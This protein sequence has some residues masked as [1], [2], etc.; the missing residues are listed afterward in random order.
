VHRP[1]LATPACAALYCAM[2]AGAAL[3]VAV[4]LAFSS[5]LPAQTVR[6][7]WAGAVYGFGAP[8]SI[9]L[10]LDSSA[11]GWTGRL[12]APAFRRDSI[13]FDS[14]LVRGDSV[15]T[16]FTVDGHSVAFHTALGA[17]RERIDGQVIV[18]KSEIGAVRLGRAGS[19]LAGALQAEARALTSPATDPAAPPHADPDSARLV[20][21]DVA[22]FWN[23]VDHAKPDSLESALEHEYLDKASVGVH[24][25]IPGRILSAV[26]LAH[27]FRVSRDRYEASRASSSRVVEAT[28]AIRAAF[29]QLKALYPPAVFPDVYFVIG[30]FNS[31]GTSSSHG[32]LIGA[33]MYNDPSKLPGIVAHELIHFEQTPR[34]HATL[35][36]RSF[37]EGSADFVGEMISGGNINSDRFQ[38]GVA[39]EHEL[40]ADFS[41][42]MHGTDYTGWLYGK[43][44]GERPAD[45]GYFIGYRIASAYYAKASDKRQALAEIIRGADVD[46]LLAAS[47]YSP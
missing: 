16:A 11:S 2:R 31:G 8:Q 34:A 17:G 3:P 45:L 10:T 43:P 41:Q 30:R 18:D 21:S 19:T 33:E 15:S 23:A 28:P 36:A 20:T 37:D 26:D 44:P 12:T 14:I 27:Q 29:H 22:L 46:A 1:H 38:Y 35:L 25:F 32:L 40:W 47:G 42:R 5:A 4:L 13:P 39:H 6:G 24:D 9:T 7:A